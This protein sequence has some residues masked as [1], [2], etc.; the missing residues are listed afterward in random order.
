MVV[1][2]FGAYFGIGCAITLTNK[3]LV[4]KA[5]KYNLEE[6]NYESQ[7]IAMIGTIFLWCFWPSFNGALAEGN[8]SMRVICNTV[9]ALSAS[10]VA[11]FATSSY[12]H[13]GKF[14]MEDVLNATLAGGV[15][16]G[17]TSDMMTH[18]ALPIGVGFLGGVVSSFGFNS[19]DFSFHDTCGVN[20][21]HGIPG[22][23]GGV[24][25]VIMCFVLGDNEAVASIFG[26]MAPNED[27]SA[28][29][30]KTTQAAMQFV[31]L[32]ISFTCGLLGGMITGYIAGQFE[33]PKP[34]FH[35]KSHF[36]E[37]EYGECQIEDDHSSSD[38]HSETKSSK[39][40]KSSS[41]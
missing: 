15:I 18:P 21:L 36:V 8:S 1:H 20:N 11:A 35:D 30:D 37:C 7:L 17:S 12:Y 14:G 22:I 27:G 19:L 31:A 29:R 5:E 28:G 9:L 13:K 38:K 23:L 32:I 26:K 10:C 34:Y 4:K 2:T 3:K 39:S 6:G 24:A 25:S 16:I 40:L 33:S 41:E